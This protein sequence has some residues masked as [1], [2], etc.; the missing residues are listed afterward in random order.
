MPSYSNRTVCICD[1]GLFVELALTLVQ[2]FG[3]VYYWSPWVSAFP[4]SNPILIGTG[5]PGITRIRDVWEVIDEVDLFVFPDVYHAP[6]QL[7]LARMGKRVW[8]ARAGEELELNR[9][10][11]KEYCSSIGISIGPYSV[12]VG[13]DA[14]RQYLR[15]N[16]DQ[17]VK[18]SATRGD[19]ETFHSCNY[20]LIE[21]QLDQL[22]HALGAKKRIT[23]FVVESAINDAVEIGF[24]GYTVDGEF[25]TNAALG[26]EV[27]DRGFLLE[28]LP[29]RELP[30][31]LRDIN[32]KLSQ[33]FGEHE[34]RG[35]LSMEVRAVGKSGYLIDPCCRLGSPPGELFMHLITN[36]PEILWEG[37][38]GTLV[39]PECSGRFGAELMLKSSW[40]EKNWQPI[41]I[42][43]AVRDFVKLKNVAELDGR[44]YFVPQFDGSTIIG[45]VVA[46]ADTIE[47]AVTK[48][49]NI[50]NQ[51]EGYYLEK[52]MDALDEAIEAYTVAKSLP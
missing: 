33:F 49:R 5:L 35:F 43:S 41:D 24:D 4:K 3:K 51:V 8:G 15:D 30:N 29:Y 16:D 10:E 39:E 36:L 26:I 12:L 20:R 44:L 46:S 28:C 13:M 52:P 42:P 9:V 6:L 50:A 19:V 11:S 34:Y 17:Y 22:E 32:S 2:S 45:G 40:A 18:V 37:S 1:N 25:T 23:E 14:L 27:K 48:V 47:S 31:C 7:Q 21:P 38:E